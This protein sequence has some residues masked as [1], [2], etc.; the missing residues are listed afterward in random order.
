MARLT[1]CVMNDVT[2]L[3]SQPKPFFSY[4]FGHNTI[5]VWWGNTSYC[6]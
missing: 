6:V 1:Q 2:A 5:S 3:R 4:G